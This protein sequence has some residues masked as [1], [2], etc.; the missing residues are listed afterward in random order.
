MNILKKLLSLII[1]FILLL[2]TI[3]RNAYAS[4]SAT[5]N[6]VKIGVFLLDTNELFLS[7]FKESLENIQKENENK[8]QFTFFDSK[9]NQGIENDNIIKA[10]NENFDLF[11]IEPV[12]FKIEELKDIFNMIANRNIPLIL[13][14]SPNKKLSNFVKGYPKTIIIGGEDEQSGILQGEVVADV[15]NTN[16]KTID[17]NK[18][19]IMQ[20]IMLK[21][22]VN[23]P[24]TTARSKYCIQALNESGIKT[25]ELSSRF[26]DWDKKCAR[27]AI[28]SF[29]L[30][31]NDKIEFIIASNDEMALGAIEALQKYGY[32]KG[33]NSKHIP[34]VG[35]GG[36]TEVKELINQ[37]VMAGTIIQ[38][39][40]DYAIAVYTVGMNLVSG[41]NP[42]NGTN[43]KFADAGNTIKIPYYPYT[44]LQ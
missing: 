15:W 16:K 25:E 1:V 23:D 7:L 20:Y 28:S 21:G 33:D 29:F 13:L 27:D 6:P 19:N 10:L 43:Y 18:D 30:G 4:S 31:Y 14:T 9:R 8:V 2:H 42:L 12:T 40:R 32:N 3:Q 11:I 36:L 26:C 41:T 34:V 37:G 22:P 39:P 24:A 44:N 17:H 35:I 38:D 5:Q